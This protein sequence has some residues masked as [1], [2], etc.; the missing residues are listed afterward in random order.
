[1]KRGLW[2]LANDE[3]ADQPLF[4][5]RF[6]AREGEMSDHA[7]S[8]LIRSRAQGCWIGEQL[9][10]GC[11]DQIR[12]VARFG[13]RVEHRF[14]FGEIQRQQRSGAQV[15]ES[16]LPVRANQHAFRM[17]EAMLKAAPVALRQAFRKRANEPHGVRYRPGARLAHDRRQRISLDAGPDKVMLAV[18]AV[19][20]REG[21]ESRV[22]GELRLSLHQPLG[23]TGLPE[24]AD[25]KQANSER[26]LGA[27]IHGPAKGS[28]A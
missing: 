3:S 26:S 16:G 25:R 6:Q 8:I 7:K 12:T 23:H 17:Q 15:Q 4:L 19:D 11:R 22:G 10:G 14:G 28:E 24:A 5:E 20:I 13:K 9:R 18:S 1:V 2:R 27:R 21:N